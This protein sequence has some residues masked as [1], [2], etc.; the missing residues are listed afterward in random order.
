MTLLEYTIY[1]EQ[2]WQGVSIAIIIDFVLLRGTLVSA[3]ATLILIVL[4]GI[5]WVVS[6]VLYCIM[7]VVFSVFAL[8]IAVYYSIFSK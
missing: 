6:F 2:F 8:G 5:V 3:V 7:C 1:S 4:M